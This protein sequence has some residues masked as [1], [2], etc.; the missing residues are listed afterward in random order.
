MKT[1][2]LARALL[3]ALLAGGLA[4][5]S[6]A[7]YNADSQTNAYGSGLTGWTGNYLVG[8]NKV[9]D[10]LLVT[11]GGVLTNANAYLGYEIP[12]SNNLAIVDGGGSTWSN[13]GV[14]AVGNKSSGNRLV[15]TNGGRVFTTS[16]AY[17]GTTATC[18]NNLAVVAGSGSTWAVGGAYI[19]VGQNGFNNQLLVLDGGQVS[20]TAVV[21]GNSSTSVSNLVVVSGA[22]SLLAASS[23]LYVG[24]NN[25]AT[26]NSSPSQNMLVV[27]NGAVVRSVGGILGNSSNANLNLALVTGGG[28]MW[29]NVGGVFNVGAFGSGN[30]TVISNG[31]AVYSG[32]S[33][34]GNYVSSTNNE[35]VVTGAGSL[36]QVSGT[37][38]VGSNANSKGTGRVLLLDG[39]GLQISG[40]LSAGFGDTGAITNSGGI[41]Q[42]TSATPTI[43]P[44]GYGNIVVTNGTVSHVGSTAANVWGS[45]GSNQLGNILYQGENTFRLNAASNTTAASPQNYTFAAGI[46]PSNYVGLEMVNGGTAWR[47]AWLNVGSGGSLLVSNTAATVGG[48]LTNSGNI[49]VVN[50]TVTWQSNVVLNSG[51]YTFAN[52][53]NVFAAN[54]QVGLGVTL[55]GSGRLVNSGTVANAG[56]LSPGNS[57]GTLAFSSNLSLL[58]SSVLVLEIAG[59][60]SSS[61]D[62][63]VVEGTLTKGGAVLVTNLGYA[64]VGGE[65]FD[66]VDAASLAGAY[67]GL[68]L[69]TL[70]GGMSWDTSLFE[71]QG[72]LSVV[73]IPE[74]GTLVGVAAALVALALARHRR[75]S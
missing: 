18:S 35:V 58:G 70:G 60:N 24:G 26:A 1:T 27:S 42:F 65:V 57:P 22:N 25:S 2:I 36:W 32:N 43:T 62:R 55:G 19:H 44:N 53:T 51:S 47:S 9:F 38:G 29:S 28:S 3:L 69:P 45:Y 23:V 67:G 48:V 7:Q 49:R 14:L 61:Y 8:S 56:T 73:A 11:G 66:F 50:A 6:R 21:I 40:A 5:P 52:A 37:L 54:L 4:L 74:P 34:V 13:V 15:I 64:F 71:S 63:L 75:V 39:G 41:L 10:V 31:G 30:R 12:A 33:A 20:G 17:V 16:I 72:V 59:T 68:T 46:S